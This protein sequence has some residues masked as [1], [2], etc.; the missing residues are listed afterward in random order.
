MPKSTLFLSAWHSRKTVKEHAW[1]F[2]NARNIILTRLVVCFS[3]TRVGPLYNGSGLARIYFPQ[4][5]CEV[6]KCSVLKGV[7]YKTDV[8]RRL[9]WAN[10]VVLPVLGFN[11]KHSCRWHYDRFC[12]IM[13]CAQN[14]HSFRCTVSKRERLWETDVVATTWSCTI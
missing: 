11:Q 4:R 8:R 9:F 3:S 1:W 13:R 7:L 14:K 5:T 6:S 12:Q 10:C 2:L